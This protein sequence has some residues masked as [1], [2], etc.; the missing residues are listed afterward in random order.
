MK[1]LRKLTRGSLPLIFLLAVGCGDSTGPSGLAGTYELVAAD[2]QQLPVT[3]QLTAFSR[4]DLVA[5]SVTLTAT[6][7]VSTSIT[8]ETTVGGQ[9][10]VSTDGGLGTYASQGSALVITYTSG[11]QEQASVSGNALTLFS[12][13]HTFVFRR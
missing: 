5:G 6:N 12:Q 8:V 1:A 13:G 4:T 2:G 7:G 3:I 10:T 9:T 11:A